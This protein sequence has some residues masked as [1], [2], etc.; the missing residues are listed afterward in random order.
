MAITTQTKENEIIT[1][2][3]THLHVGKYHNN[4]DPT[5]SSAQKQKNRVVSRVAVVELAIT[6]GKQENKTNS[7]VDITKIQL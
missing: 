4:T 6:Q 7:R 1:R 5:N 2:Y 3:K